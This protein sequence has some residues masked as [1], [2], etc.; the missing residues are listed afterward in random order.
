MTHQTLNESTDDELPPQRIAITIF[1]REK[2]ALEEGEEFEELFLWKLETKF[3]G[4]KL[5]I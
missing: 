4:A 1:N 3:E 2:W 5:A